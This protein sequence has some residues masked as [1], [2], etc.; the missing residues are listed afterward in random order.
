MRMRN[1][2]DAVIGKKDEREFDSLT[3]VLRV[4]NNVKCID[5]EQF[6]NTVRLFSGKNSR[7][8][9]AGEVS[10]ALIR[11]LSNFFF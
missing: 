8:K 6:R 4:W 3:K 10:E 5:E 1:S 11:E 9:T 7:T 2:S